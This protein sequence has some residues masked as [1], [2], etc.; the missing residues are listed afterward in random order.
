MDRRDVRILSS[1]SSPEKD[2]DNVKPMAVD[3]YNA[4]MPG[5]DSA[6]QMRHGRQIARLRLKR[7]YRKLFFNNVDVA[8]SMHIS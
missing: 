6:D 8:W 7:W 3:E 5:V 4:V 2:I 1:F